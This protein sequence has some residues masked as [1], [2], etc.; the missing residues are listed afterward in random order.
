MDWLVG[1]LVG[2]YLFQNDW[3]GFGKKERWFPALVHCLIYTFCVWGFTWWPVWTL[4][5]VFFSHLVIDKTMIVRDYARFVGRE[6][7]IDPKPDNRFFPWSWVVIDNSIHIVSLY[8]I[9]KMVEHQVVSW[10]VTKLV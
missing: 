10:L 5:L 7:F 4:P 2:D 3:M 8:A 9:D 1:H 6:A